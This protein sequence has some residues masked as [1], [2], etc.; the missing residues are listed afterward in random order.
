MSVMPPALR[1][2]LTLN[3]A[4][5]KVA[6]WTEPWLPTAVTTFT[7]PLRA[8][9]VEPTGI[10]EPSGSGANSDAPGVFTSIEPDC[11][12][13]PTVEPSTGLPESVASMTAGSWTGAG[14]SPPEEGDGSVVVEPS[15]PE[16]GVEPEPEPELES[17]PDPDPESCPELSP[18]PESCPELSP[19]PEPPEDPSLPESPS[20]V[21]GGGGGGGS[22]V[23]NDLSA[24]RAVLRS[25]VA[26]IR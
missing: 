10:V 21:G 13:A 7:L 18:E 19:E 25:P 9:T 22:S 8:S 16:G 4:P 17:D 12:A 3:I 24:P 11:G 6:V 5:W 23:V 2:C 15:P 14:S 20:P 26:T 1:L